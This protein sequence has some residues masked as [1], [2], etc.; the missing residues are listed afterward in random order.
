VFCLQ[1]IAAI[2]AVKALGRPLEKV[3]SKGRKSSMKEADFLSLQKP[4]TP[5]EGGNH[6][7]FV[8]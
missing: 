1:R 5:I 8:L 2:Q 3:F 7:L 6:E 4:A